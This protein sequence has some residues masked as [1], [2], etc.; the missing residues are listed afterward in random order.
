MQ[1][2]SDSRRE[3]YV[4]PNAT[5]DDLPIDGEYELPPVAEMDP[6][7][8]DNMS[9]P[10]LYAGDVVIIVNDGEVSAA[11]MIMDK[12]EGHVT[13]YLI[14]TGIPKSVADN[15]FSSRLFQA[16]RVHVFE[17]VGEE[18]EVP[19]VEFDAS[20]LRTPDEERPR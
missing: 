19:D 9:D 1:T 11:E 7:V 14:D 4:H 15:I 10:K 12:E 2:F 16:D 13:V 17:A 5:T 6:F 8:P 3:I 20:R 18:I